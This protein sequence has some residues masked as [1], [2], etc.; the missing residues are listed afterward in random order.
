MVSSL[1]TTRY[2]VFEFCQAGTPGSC[3]RT[4]KP[5]QPPPNA[6]TSAL[7]RSN[8][9]SNFCAL[10]PNTPSPV[11]FTVPVLKSRLGDVVQFAWSESCVVRSTTGYAASC[12]VI[13]SD[14]DT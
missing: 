11:A 12:T 13:V 2:P 14:A 7:K 6:P 1:I 3:E 5:Y 4:W 8:P 10:Y 9:S